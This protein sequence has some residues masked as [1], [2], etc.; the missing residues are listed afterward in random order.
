[1]DSEVDLEYSLN[2][3]YVYFVA[4]LSLNRLNNVY[5]LIVRVSDH[6]REGR[7]ESFFVKP[8][9]YFGYNLSLFLGESLLYYVPV[10]TVALVFSCLTG[11]IEA[12][13]GFVVLAIVSQFFCFLV[14]MI[15][16][17]V[18]FWVVRPDMVLSFQVVLFGVFG[19]TLMPLSFWPSSILP[20]MEYN[21]FR[22][23]IGGPAEFLLRPSLELLITL[24]WMFVCWGVAFSVLFSI[25][26]HQGSKRYAGAGG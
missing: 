18:A 13:V 16:A 23:M 7:L 11:N 21:P 4:V 22:L 26:F 25:A 3:T 14:G 2:E 10:F 12:G 5:D 19:G 15:M 20:I 24:G 8:I 1:M 17:V 6:V 9:S